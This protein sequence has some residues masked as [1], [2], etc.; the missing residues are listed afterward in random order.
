MTGWNT[1]DAPNKLNDILQAVKS[2]PHLPLA[3]PRRG[4][5]FNL[6]ST[7]RVCAPPAKSGC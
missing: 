1:K 7:A 4:L 6:L 5:R 3:A 2:E